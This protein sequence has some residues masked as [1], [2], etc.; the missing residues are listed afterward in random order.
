MNQTHDRSD[1]QPPGLILFPHIPKTAGT[2]MISIFGNIFGENNV[3]RIRPRLDDDPRSLIRAAV[4]SHTV[5]IGH[6]NVPYWLEFFGEGTAVTVLRD[7][8]YRVLSLFRFLHMQPPAELEPLGL[9]HGF[10]IEEFLEGKASLLVNQVTNGMTFFL[11]GNSQEGGVSTDC[12]H[13]TLYQ[14]AVRNLSLVKVA[15][16]D[17]LGTTLNEWCKSWGVPFDIR[18]PSDNVTSD[19]AG[20]LSHEVHMEILRRNALD[21]AL[22]DYARFRSGHAYWNA[23]SVFRVVLGAGTPIA[24]VPGRMGFHNTDEGLAWIREGGGEINCFSE[25]LTCTIGLNIYTIT[26]GYP[27]D[28]VKITVNGSLV[29]PRIESTDKQD[30]TLSF[31]HTLVPGLNRIN[32]SPPVFILVNELH[33]GSGD[34]RKLSFALKH[35]S[36]Y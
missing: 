7:P 33:P 8:V 30:F 22:Y 20:P 9:H 15:F 17:T 3:C 10:S 34:H 16:T 13:T 27:L 6:I 5:V 19:L 25:G 28:R 24:E 36:F 14:E 12:D 4:R 26:G 1:R 23:R 21:L 2:S 18:L 32:I 31:K 29:R 11:G 35:V